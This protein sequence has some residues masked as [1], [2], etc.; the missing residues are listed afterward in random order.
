MKTTTSLLILTSLIPLLLAQ[1][2]PIP[3]PE[4]GSYAC[5]GFTSGQSYCAGPSL[6]SP[7]IFRCI[8]NV[9]QPGNCDDN[10][11]GIAP[12]GVKAF[13]PCYQAS[14]S[15]GDA[16]CS[17]EEIGYPDNGAPFYISNGAP[18]VSGSSTTVTVTA[19]AA[20]TVENSSETPTTTTIIT[21]TL[22]PSSTVS[23]VTVSE[24][25][26]TTTSTS[27][28]STTTATTTGITT[29]LV[30]PITIVSAT[31]STT[32]ESVPTSS[33]P[34]ATQFA[35]TAVRVTEC[36]ALG[37]MGMLAALLM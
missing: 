36:W 21:T 5:L 27:T 26:T 31:T 18:V 15:S 4:N 11:A 7:I 1:I 19:T 2:I 12:V 10:L 13:A 25:A 37:A 28:T 6:T 20:S 14:P 35:G 3:I 9:G 29:Y 24:A 8:N 34:S 23:I 32:T 33:T 17:F 16:V 30:T 22:T